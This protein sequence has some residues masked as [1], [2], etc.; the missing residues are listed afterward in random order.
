MRQIAA[1]F[2]FLA[3]TLQGGFAVPANPLSVSQ[4]QQNHVFEGEWTMPVILVDFP[5]RPF[6][7]T[8]EEFEEIFNGAVRNYFLENSSGKF[9]LR[10]NIYGPFTLPDSISVYGTFRWRLGN[11]TIQVAR[12]HG[13]DPTIYPHPLPDFEYDPWTTYS[14]Y[15]G[16][17]IIFAGYC[18]SE[19]VSRDESVWSHS[20][21]WFFFDDNNIERN[22]RYGASP[23]LRGRSGSNI[24]HIGIKVHEI[25]HSIFHIEDFYGS[26]G[27]VA[28]G[29]WCI[30]ASGS[31]NFIPPR[32]SAYPRAR[33]GWATVI[34]LNETAANI[35]LPNP[36]LHDIVYRIDTQTED[37][38]FLIENRQRVGVD[39]NVPA[40]G[41]LIYH[42]NRNNRLFLWNANPEW[43]GYYIK[44]AGCLAQNGCGGNS[45][46]RANDVFP[47]TEGAITHNKFTDY[48]VPN[49]LSWAGEKTDKPITNIRHNTLTRTITFDFMMT[50]TWNSDTP[51]TLID[52]M[53]VVISVG[54]SR[55]LQIPPNS[56]ITIIG[57][58]DNL[59]DNSNRTI[60][61][62]IPFNSKVIWKAKYAGTI[63]Q[64]LM[65]RGDGE[66]IMTD[67]GLIVNYD[68]TSCKLS[69]LPENARVSWRLSQPTGIIYGNDEFLPIANVSARHNFDNWTL[70]KEPN[71]TDFGE[72][73]RIC[74]ICTQTETTPT[75]ERNPENH[76]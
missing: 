3:L 18:Q 65:I 14:N 63:P 62:H 29:P 32:F 11:H 1:I 35:T 2:L 16:V 69:I 61:I 48:T 56:T 53:T 67:G 71:C 20:D 4:S 72:I 68:P 42:V 59:F 60:G 46:A 76:A 37:E 43:R 47:R 41:M 34:T 57:E 51:P 73:S 66:L 74:Q 70:S 10:A 38:Y 23:E 50:T 28:L 12:Q 31:W 26:S 8:K 36:A 52:Q 24:G 19:G 6:T 75:P 40:D 58:T 45:T 21:G 49:S 44:Q 27:S 15:I 7:K 33:L 55:T 54:A 5:D 39:I 30:M 13:F 22:G 25:G 17:H 9:D 64:N